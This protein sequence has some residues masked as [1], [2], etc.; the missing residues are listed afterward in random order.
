MLRQTSNGQCGTPNLVRFESLSIQYAK[1]YLSEYLGLDKMTE[2]F[3]YLNIWLQ[4]G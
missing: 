1:V 4:Q 3:I 2:N